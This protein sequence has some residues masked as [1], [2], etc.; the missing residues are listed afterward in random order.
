MFG[1]QMICLFFFSCPALT[2]FPAFFGEERRRRSLVTFKDDDDGDD[3]DD[4]EGLLSVIW[5]RYI[6]VVDPLS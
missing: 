1:S 6:S 5:F 3:D 4:D 2:R